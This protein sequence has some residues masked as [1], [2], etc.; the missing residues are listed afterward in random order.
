MAVP[1]VK[2]RM[3]GLIKGKALFKRKALALSRFIFEI[4]NKN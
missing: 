2:P 4:Q 1:Q 3:G